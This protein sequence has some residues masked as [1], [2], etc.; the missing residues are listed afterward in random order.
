[1]ELVAT[2]GGQAP[3]VLFATPTFEKSVS[4]DYHASML[5][6]QTE[7]VKHRIAFGSRLIAGNQ[8]IDVAR[9]TLVDHFLNSEDHFTD[10]VFIDAD[11]GWDAKAIPRILSHPQG[12]VA[13]LPPKKCEEPS[14]H[15]NAITGK[16]ENGLFQALEAGTGLMRIKREVFER[17][18]AAFPELK[19]M[20]DKENGWPH[21]PYFQRGNTKYGGWLGEDIFFCRQLIAMGEFVWIDSDVT[22]TH[23]GSKV[24]KGNFYEHAVS[25]GLL[26]LA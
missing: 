22:F 10:L 25:S 4:V 2:N 3:V 6:T 12:V 1:M 9:N 8:F 16:I 23:R 17:M 24:W 5:D 15:S 26:K 21:T 18:D 11:Q 14:Y 13:A 7:C 19:Q 20:I